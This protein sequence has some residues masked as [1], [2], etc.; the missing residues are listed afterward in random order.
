LFAIPGALRPWPAGAETGKAKSDATHRF[1]CDS[2]RCRRSPRG[3]QAWIARAGSPAEGAHHSAHP[4]STQWHRDRDL[5]LERIHAFLAIHDRIRHY[6]SLV[7]GPT[8][9]VLG[10]HDPEADRLRVQHELWLDEA[11]RAWDAIGVTSG[12]RV[13]DLGCGPGLV[14][15]ALAARVGPSGRA[16][17][18]ELS[19]AFAAQARARCARFGSAVAIEEVD[20]SASQLPGDL[21]TCFDAAWIRWLLMFLPDPGRV[22]SLAHQ[23]L[24]PGG[25]IAIHEYIHYS[26]YGLLDGGPRIAEFVQH[27]MA[28][29]RKSGGDA[30]VARRLPALLTKHGFELVQVR[31]IARVARPSDALWQ[32]PAGFV[33]TYAPRLVE[34]GYSDHEWLESTLAELSAAE[35]DSSSV[36]MCPTLLEVVARRL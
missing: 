28:S 10:T 15:E 20:L 34:L 19:P 23:A 36:L 7:S 26:T 31:P 29:F 24:R 12:A 18:I 30:N 35:R 33:R 3:S 22:L 8:D 9:Y 14:T 13:I 2:W 25:M 16:V 4:A 32:W 6:R 11:S 5:E 17:G 21:R 1:R 27:A